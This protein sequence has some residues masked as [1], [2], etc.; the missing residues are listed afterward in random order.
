MAPKSAAD[1]DSD[2]REDTARHKYSELVQAARNGDPESL[3]Q[4]LG[5]VYGYLKFVAAR[6]GWPLNSGQC[7]L[8]DLAQQGAVEICKGFS[9]FRGNCT[10]EFLGWVRMIIRHNA[11]D[12]R[13]RHRRHAQKAGLIGHN[14]VTTPSKDNP[15]AQAIQRESA[16]DVKAAL[17]RLPEHYAE[18]LRLKTWE[19]KTCAQIGH[20]TER[21]EDAVRKVWCRA[22]VCLRKEL[23]SPPLAN[24]RS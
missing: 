7:G 4:L 3:N 19:G 14:G 22:L 12:E 21:S 2:C 15:L 13:Q 16:A 18:V 23:E 9:S 10:R 6:E 17:A 1:S 20:Q 24:A 11:S 8:S 5:A